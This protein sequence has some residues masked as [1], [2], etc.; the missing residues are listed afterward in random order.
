MMQRVMNLNRQ[1]LRNM[2]QHELLCCVF[3][4]SDRVLLLVLLLWD[5]IDDGSFAVSNSR[6]S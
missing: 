6:G 1:L 3:G 5:R 2:L 4:I